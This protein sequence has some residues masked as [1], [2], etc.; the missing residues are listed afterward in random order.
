MTPAADP[1]RALLSPEAVRERCGELCKLALADELEHFRVNEA[2]LDAVAT[3]VVAEVRRN[4]PRLQVPFH[5]RWRHFELGG[6]DLWAAVAAR[7]AGGDRHAFAR[8]RF[9]LAIV[10]VLLDAGAGPEWRYRDEATGLTLGR[11]EGLALA[12]LRIFESGLLSAPGGGEPLRVDAERLVGLRDR[13]LADAMQVSAANPLVGVEQRAELLRRLGRTLSAQ[14]DVFERHGEL[15]PGH[16]Y[17]HLAARAVDT[18]LEAREILVALLLTLGDIW[19]RGRTLGDVRAGDVATHPLIRRDDASDHLLPLH[20]LSQWLAYSL[21]EPL[22]DAGIEVTAPDAL[23]GLAEYRNG[24]LLL[25][26]GVLELR[27]PGA[28]ERVHAPD[29][30]L[31]VEWRALTVALLDRVAARVRELLALD[32]ATLPLAAVLQGGTWSAGRRIA[33][34]LRADGGPPLRVASDGTLF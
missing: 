2:A 14:R 9:D 23:T 29:A 17:D 4:Y 18:R 33:A 31:V 1:L 26:A 7:H 34:E 24:G 8:S 10:S 19:P 13:Q 32:A 25:D 6:E 20:K 16:L 30:A 22:V 5:S 15:R 11:S 3:R 28:R 21:I 27:D 12:S